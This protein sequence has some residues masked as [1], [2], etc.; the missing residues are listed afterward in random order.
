MESGDQSHEHKR[1]PTLV[2]VVRNHAVK[3]WLEPTTGDVNFHVKGCA[4][5][6]G[7]G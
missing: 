2:V 7:E 5:R 4:E 1:S 3:L 6:V